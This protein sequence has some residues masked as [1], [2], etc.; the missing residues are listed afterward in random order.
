MERS[1]AEFAPL[2]QLREHFNLIDPNTNIQGYDFYNEKT[3]EQT[4]QV[5]RTT[6]LMRKIA[7]TGGLDYRW[8]A[9]ARSEY[10]L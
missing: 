1:R 8:D 10:P 3:I 7:E 5:F 9:P 4:N 6:S 2:I